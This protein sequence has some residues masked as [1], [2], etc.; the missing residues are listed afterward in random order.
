M[1]KQQYFLW[2]YMQFTLLNK[3]YL[4][5]GMILFALILNPFPFIPVVIRL[6]RYK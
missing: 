1:Q 2:V 3:N 6:F 5:Y 4:E